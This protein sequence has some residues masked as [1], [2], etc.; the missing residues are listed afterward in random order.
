MNFRL[1]GILALVAAGLGLLI[2]FWDRDDDTARA[3]MERARR[4]FRFEPARVDR[5]RIES[6]DLSIECR[7]HGRQWHLVRPMDARADSIAIERLLDALQ[8]LPRGDI[9]LPSRRAENPYAPYGL[10]DP[11]ASISIIEGSITNRILIGRRTPLGDGIYVR[12]SDHAGLARIDTSLL[13]LLPA[14]AEALRDR[15]L[16]SGTPAAIERLDVRGPSGYVQLARQPD[17]AWRMFQPF[18]ARADSATVAALVEQL[19]SCSVVQ[20]VQDAVADLAPY[21][22]DGQ[23]ALTA[24]VN[25]D[26]G[27][28]SQVLAIGDPLPNA[29]NLVY[30][31]LQAETSVYAVPAA[32]R[33]ALLVRPDDLRDRRIPGTDPNAIA[34]VRIEEGESVL[35]FARADGDSWQLLSPVRAPAEPA[36]IDDLLRL[37]ANVRLTAFETKAP[38]NAPPFARTIRI[39]RQPAGSA[40]VVLRLGPHPGDPASARIAI[41]GDSSVA[42]SAPPSLL[43]FTLDSLAYRSRDIL[44]LPLGDVAEIR[45]ATADQT[46]QAA[47]DSATGAWSPDAPWIPRVL[48]ALSPLRAESLLAQGPQAAREGLDPPYLSIEVGLRGQTGLATLL[49]VGDELSPGGPRRAAIR[50]RD[51]AFAL[52]PDTVEALRPSPPEN[53]E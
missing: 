8:E 11:R 19:L 39:E 35:E 1:T 36:A 13:G 44:S 24:V 4:A 25:T 17:G 16:L 23:S 45:V 12:Q 10:D 20:F 9:V 38:S 42:L 27:D 40:P 14:G 33:Q 43:D 52:S 29:T 34:R 41:E 15:S 18:T 48:A 46:I 30:A 3:R 31:R 51:L 2:A 22:L 21:G 5:L 37:W 49:L 6:G 32:V 50:G 53:A 7:L 47:C 26:S 28:G